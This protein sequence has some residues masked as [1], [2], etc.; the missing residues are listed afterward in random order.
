MLGRAVYKF[1]AKSAERAQSMANRVSTDRLFSDLLRLSCKG[2]PLLAAAR[3]GS[4]S[5]DMTM[6]SKFGGVCG[7]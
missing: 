5:G 7:S 1:H 6:D 2:S 4:E 3:T